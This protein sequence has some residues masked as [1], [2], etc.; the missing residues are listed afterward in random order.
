MMKR[1]R[2]ERGSALMAAM[3]A[4]FLMVMIGMATYS[5]VDTQ[6]KTSTQERAGESSFNHSDSLANAEAFQVSQ[7]WKTGASMPDCSYSGGT[8]N[9][10]LCP[11]V[12]VLQSAF[13]GVDFSKGSTWTVKVRDNTGTSPCQ[14]RPTVSTC[15][16][17]YDDATVLANPRNDANADGELWIR[18]QTVVANRRRTVVE[19]VR[20]N[21][22]PIDAPRT[23]VSA[24][25]VTFAGSKK[26]RIWT[27]GAQ[28]VV[29]CPGAATV[30]PPDPK[31]C[32]SQRSSNNDQIQ[33]ASGTYSS[34]SSVLT[35]S[36]V[37]QLRTRAQT[38]GGYYTTCPTSPQQS[39][40]FIEG[41]A[42]CGPSSLPPTGPGSYGVYVLA[43][44]SFNYSGSGD[45]WGLMYIL[46]GNF[47]SNGNHNWH[48][49]VNVDG[50][51]TANFGTSGNTSLKFDISAFNEL[52]TYG[53]AQ[54]I[55]P[56]FREIDTTT[57]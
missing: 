29:R 22:I 6:I 16:Y 54:V 47:D 4:M 21:R 33:P 57:P 18:A 20:V 8:A 28:V 41:P 10:N 25:K 34:T 45:Y 52:Y 5:Y 39:L 23:A 46:N 43:S 37:S 40:V 11:P 7:A 14:N 2:S 9:S 55:R 50:Q 30:S 53:D 31:K 48:G 24:G 32:I 19:R 49:S 1:L 42:N 3:A 15:S 36:S 17:F 35:T 27:G 56:S 44:G 38:E 51:G 26:L 13:Q 12:S